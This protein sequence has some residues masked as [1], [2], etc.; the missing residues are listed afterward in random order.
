[1]KSIIHSNGIFKQYLW[2]THCTI[3]AS[4]GPPLQLSVEVTLP[5]SGFLHSRNKSTV[6]LLNVFPKTTASEVWVLSGQI[7]TNTPSDQLPWGGVSGDQSLPTAKHTSKCDGAAAGRAVTSTLWPRSRHCHHVAMAPQERQRQ[8]RRQHDRGGVEMT[9]PCR[10]IHLLTN[11]QAR[12][13]S[14][15]LK[16]V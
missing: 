3:C 9:K 11:F 8:T 6:S 12:N 4:V 10:K 13:S 14:I 2:T 1:M 5:V 15:A 7:L 16:S